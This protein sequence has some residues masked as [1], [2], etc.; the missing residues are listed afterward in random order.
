ME[1]GPYYGKNLDALWDCLST[2]IERPIRIPWCH[3]DLSK[4]YL[5]SDLIKSSRF[6]KG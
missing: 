6:S 1:F 3:S 2:D 4:K 5:E